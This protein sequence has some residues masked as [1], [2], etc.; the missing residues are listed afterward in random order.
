MSAA[1][2]TIW[3]EREALYVGCT[4]DLTRRMRE[5]DH[6]SRFMA[7]ARWI[8][9]VEFADWETAHR[10][11]NLRIA[12][13][14]PVHNRQF[15]PRRDSVALRTENE[16][17]WAEWERDCLSVKARALAAVKASAA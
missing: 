9:V 3:G 14:R 6:T 5:H 15:N 1:V 7:D 17:L 11:E 13:I 12:K 16:R 4:R 2:Y 8:A 10:E